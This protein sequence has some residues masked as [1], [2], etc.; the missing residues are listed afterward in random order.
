MVRSITAF[1]QYV[2]YHFHA[3]DEKIVYGLGAIKGVVNRPC[4]CD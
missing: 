3:S 2:L 4:K 1:G